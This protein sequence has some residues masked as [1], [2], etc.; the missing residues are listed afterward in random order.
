[1]IRRPPRS[2]LFP[3]TT[4][5]RSL[6]GKHGPVALLVLEATRPE[7]VETTRYHDLLLHEVV[8]LNAET[9]RGAVEVAAQ[10]A[11]QAV[12]LIPDQRT[13]D[14]GLLPPHIGCDTGAQWVGTLA[15]RVVAILGIR[16][17]DD[18]E[19]SIDERRDVEGQLASIQ[20]IEPRHTV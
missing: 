17:A 19:A 12:E 1:M 4:L 13:V 15:A 20:E 18:T 6:H 9:G 3:Y 8:G 16:R 14:V 10:L 5:F 11:R 7:L 2:T